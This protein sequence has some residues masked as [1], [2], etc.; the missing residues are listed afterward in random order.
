MK[1]TL[2]RPADHESLLGFLVCV[3]LGSGTALAIL[4]WVTGGLNIIGA[5]VIG[6]ALGV[7]VL[8]GGVARER[9]VSRLYHF[10]N[11]AAR[12]YGRKASR[13]VTA[14][15][16]WT[17]FTALAVAGERGSLQLGHSPWLKRGT[18]PASAYAHSAGGPTS[19]N[20][21]G[22]YQDFARWAIR[23]KR[24]WAL[25]LIPFFWL[26]RSFETGKASGTGSS[27]IYTLY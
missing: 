17:L 11:R 5:L 8:L 16:Y 2:P 10:W 24:Y 25:V 22:P 27:T 15:W 14:V 12:A 18:L 9:I 6:T 4:T 20:G 7:G 1:L 26:L 13:V 3:S 19:G 21:Q 23:S